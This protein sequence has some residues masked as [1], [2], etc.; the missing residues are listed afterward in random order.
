MY[1]GV[2]NGNLELLQLLIQNGGDVYDATK[3]NT[4]C[5][6]LAVSEGHLDICKMFL[7][8]YQFDIN[9]A[10]NNGWTALHF[11]EEN[12]NFELF[13]FIVQNGIDIYNRTKCK[14]TSLH[15]ASSEGHLKICQWV[16]AQYN[17]DACKKRGEYDTSTK[18]KTRFGQIFFDKFLNARTTEGNTSLHLAVL[19]IHVDVRKFLLTCNVDITYENLNGETPRDIAKR[20]GYR[21]VLDVMKDK[22]DRLGKQSMF[23]HSNEVYISCLN[24][25]IIKSE[26]FLRNCAIC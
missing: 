19:G 8:I 6:H 25:K 4:N 3:D 22:Y 16:A 17:F 7:N 24:I 12:G 18:D 23:L 14:M 9:T 5:I 21:S 11:G 2:E 10:N 15:I 20:E 26:S 13:K 1:Y